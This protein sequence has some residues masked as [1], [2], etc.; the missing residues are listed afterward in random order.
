M[1]VD[2]AMVMMMVGAWRGQV[3]NLSRSVGDL[4]RLLDTTTTHS[5]AHEAEPAN[6]VLGRSMRRSARP[7][8]CSEPHSRMNEH[9]KCGL[10][11]S[12]T[13]SG[14]YLGTPEH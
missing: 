11:S 4:M 9:G 8:H 7:R 2:I 14:L 3:P 12:D 10:G 6:S 1:E 13:G 5:I